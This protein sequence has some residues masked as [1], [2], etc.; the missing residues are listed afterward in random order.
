MNFAK[1][2]F[3]STIFSKIIFARILNKAQI[4]T[5]ENQDYRNSFY[6]WI[7]RLEG[8]KEARRRLDDVLCKDFKKKGIFKN[9]L[10]YYKGLRD[11]HIAIGIAGQNDE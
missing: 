6:I 1:P 4:Q 11:L 9:E 10:N 5:A 2:N 3:A 7:H 8:R